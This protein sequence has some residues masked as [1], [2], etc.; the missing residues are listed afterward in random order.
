MLTRLTKWR[1]LVPLLVLVLL[2]SAGMSTT[3][4]LLSGSSGAFVSSLGGGTNIVVLSGGGRV[5]ETGAID[6]RQVQDATDLPGVL[7]ASPEV[8]A[9]VL[10]LG[11]VVVARG[12]DWPEF[13]AIQPVTIKGAGE[14][15]AGSEV[16]IGVR[17]AERL[18]VAA[19]DSLELRGLLA[20]ATTT[21]KVGAVFS[22]GQPFDDQVLA[23]LPMAQS[24]RGLSG[25]QVTFV[26]LKVDPAVFNQTQL[27]QTLRGVPSSAGRG[28]QPNPFI[29]Q[30]QL[31][32]TSS[33]IT[34]LPAG[35]NSQPTLATALTKGLGLVQTAFESLDAVVLL[36]SL[37]AVYFATANWLEGLRPTAE[38]LS[39]LGLAGRSLLLWLL[40]AAV[41]AAIVAGIAGYLLACLTVQSLSGSGALSFFFQPLVV[42]VDP[43]TA[44][45]ACVGPAAAVALS[46]LIAHGRAKPAIGGVR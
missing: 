1:Q 40:V 11:S 33:L 38:T 12:V 34:I 35:G 10:A 32:P 31:A 42:T 19:G 17:L 43:D 37:L 25:D 9:P 7:A 22:A 41:P 21:A 3:A 29:Q 18:G 13:T 39:S 8:Y 26:R 24:L 20:N 16:Y 45:L 30:L 36:V 14:P 2:L 23:P 5:P 6:L 28:G 15:L 4:M 46:I 44:A 27:V